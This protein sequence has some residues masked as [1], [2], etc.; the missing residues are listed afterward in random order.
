[1]KLVKKALLGLALTAFAA[2]NAYADPT[3]TDTVFVFAD[4]SAPGTLVSYD[5][6]EGG[7]N[8]TAGETFSYDFLFNTPPSDPTTSFIFK[9]VA[10]FANAVSFES[11]LFSY[12]GDVSN[13]PGYT[14]INAGN[15]V[16]GAGWLDSGLYDL[17]VTGTFLA[18]GAGFT[19]LA[20]DDVT[21]LSGNVPEPMSLALVGLGL[22]GLGGVRRRRAGKPAALAA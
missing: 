16:A 20:L 22:V 2:V 1:M 10:D 3:Y 8:V 12:Y 9:V 13:V 6:G 15:A 17:N 5:F 18:N 7:T 11:L 4:T 19:G 21:D 14:L